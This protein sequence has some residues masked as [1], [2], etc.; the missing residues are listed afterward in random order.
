[1]YNLY[2]V[3]GDF[4]PLNTILSVGDLLEERLFPILFG[5]RVGPSC[6]EHICNHFRD[7]LEAFEEHIGTIINRILDNVKSSIKI[8]RKDRRQM[9]L[10]SFGSGCYIERVMSKFPKEF[11]SIHKDCGY[12]S[13]PKL[14]FLLNMLD[15]LSSAGFGSGDFLDDLFEK[16]FSNLSALVLFDS[17]DKYLFDKF[18]GEYGIETYTIIDYIQRLIEEEEVYLPDLHGI[19]LNVI[20]PANDLLKQDFEKLKK[21]ISLFP[22]VDYIESNLSIHSFYCYGDDGLE[23]L[24][25]NGGI[26]TVVR[27]FDRL[28]HHIVLSVDAYTVE[29]LY[30][31]FRKYPYVVGFVPQFIYSSF[32]RGERI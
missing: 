19:V 32:R 5:F 6:K 2:N 15:F 21:I 16:Y 17:F 12:V 3:C 20:T 10:V 27:M 29:Y 25:M 26:E 28:P 14:M 30:R 31:V 18:F 13:L 11:I 24:S 23:G 8:V 7:E 9:L 1:M 4:K 22:G